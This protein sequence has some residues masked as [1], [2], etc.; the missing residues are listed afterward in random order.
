MR[1]LFLAFLLPQLAQAA[2]CDFTPKVLKRAKGG[3]TALWQLPN[4]AELHQP[5]NPPE[6]NYLHYVSWVRSKTNL[7]AV[8]LLRN[9]SAVVQKVLRELG[10]GNSAFRDALLLG[11]RNLDRI[12]RGEVGQI[13]PMNCLESI[14][15]RE[16]LKVV[17]LRECAQETYVSILRKGDQLT[18]IA[19]LYPGDKGSEGIAAESS[20]ARKER[21]ALTKKGWKLVGHFHNHPFQFDNPYGDLGGATAPSGPD[22][23]VYQSA[24]VEFALIS[25]GIETIELTAKDL[26]K[27]ER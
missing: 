25:N 21:R 11:E 27:L 5:V 24:G 12:L 10:P 2:D 8:G 7:D 3:Y 15:F 20:A 14:P 1:F 26:T 16:F 23:G 18:L 17:D 9:H 13:R 6:E 4:S 22:L 19:D